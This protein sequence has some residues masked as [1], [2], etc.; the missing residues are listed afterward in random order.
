VEVVARTLETE[1]RAA[2]DGGMDPGWLAWALSQ[3]E[4]AP[5]PGMVAELEL[6]Q[7]RLFRDDLVGK[8]LAVAG[9]RDP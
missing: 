5:L 1:G 3:I 7:L 4:I 2:K 6:D 9:A 8:L